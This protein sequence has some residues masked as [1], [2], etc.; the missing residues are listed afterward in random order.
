MTAVNLGL[1]TLE[2]M[3]GAPW[4]N[5]WILDKFVKFLHGDILEV[6]CG[7]GNFTSSLTKY[8]NVWAID[9]NKEYIS[10]MHLKANM[11]FGDIEK[12][13]Y[14]FGKKTFDTI[15]CLNVLEHIKDDEA[16]LNN[17]FKLL[18]E[19]GKLILLVPSHK[20]LYGE[21]DKGIDHFRR[22]EKDELNKRL[23]KIGFKI[24]KS[25]KLNLFGALGWFVAGKILKQ[26]AVK[27]GN[28]KVFSLFA[29]FL[30]K[31]EDLVEPPIGIS[32]LLIAQKP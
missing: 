25:R 27:G 24:A 15:V 32:I 14:F 10:K 11:G 13:K 2:S 30:L 21:I 26:K 23:Q 4:Y 9:I 19:G 7:I 3:K 16:A 5:R 18:K 28:V 29:P 31:L 6:G 17:L 22:Y 1:Q 20:F 8:G 12:G